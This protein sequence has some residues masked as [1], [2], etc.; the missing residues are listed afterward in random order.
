MKRKRR[1]T[2]L[3]D[4]LV[5]ILP[6]LEQIETV[7]D[8]IIAARDF[9]GFPYKIFTTSSTMRYESHVIH[10]MIS[11][12][13]S[14]TG[15]RSFVSDDGHLIALDVNYTNVS[16]ISGNT[17]PHTIW[18]HDGHKPHLLDESIF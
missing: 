1:K 6:T 4:S 3:I 13:T 2:P 15:K 16:G 7:H 18:Y 5:S 11:S 12:R 8:E 17:M 9:G 14:F 10:Y